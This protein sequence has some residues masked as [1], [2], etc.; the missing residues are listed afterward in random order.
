[1]PPM[2]P[3]DTLVWLG[4]ISVLMWMIS[5]PLIAV[6]GVLGGIKDG[7]VDTGRYLVTPEPALML[8][9]QMGTD[10]RRIK[11]SDMLRPYDLDW[12]RYGAF[13]EF[14]ARVGNLFEIADSEVR[15]RYEDAEGDV[16]SI[17]CADELVEAVHLAKEG[18][19]KTKPTLIHLVVDTGS[20]KK[21]GDEEQTPVAGIDEL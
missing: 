3:I 13:D 10:I 1:M 15:V 7:I 4:V 8:K 12:D 19:L 17:T 14:K 6:I 9:L 11:L 16:L 18:K 2:G 21:P 20:Q 5:D